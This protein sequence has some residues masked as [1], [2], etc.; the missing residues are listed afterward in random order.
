M[1]SVMLPEKT[2]T[3][4]ARDDLTGGQWSLERSPDLFEASLTGVFAVGDVRYGNIRR[5]A[6]AVGEGSIVLSFVH[7][8]L[9]E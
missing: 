8:A 4:L 6:S 3:D 1:G 9:S 5:V 2:G 7:R